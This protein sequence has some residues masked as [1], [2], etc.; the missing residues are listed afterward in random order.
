[1][2]R[3]G[4]DYDEDYPNAGAL[5]MQR[6]KNAAKGRRGQALFR[7]LL[8]ALDA[9]PV[10]E[11]ASRAVVRKGECCALGSLALHR[12]IDLSP[13]ELPEGEDED[14]DGDW[15]TEWLRDEL[16]IV[17]CLAREIVYENDDC[18]P[19]GETPAERWVRMRNLVTKNITAKPET[20]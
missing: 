16:G 9:M 12:G 17:D 2:S 1:M 5:Y 8:E 15:S 18:G 20:A 4:Y 11:L 10:K 13:I 6:V 7:E 14:D 19:A 3:H